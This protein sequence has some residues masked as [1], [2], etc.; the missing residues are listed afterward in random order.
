[1]NFLITLLRLLSVFFF[2]IGYFT[3]IIII[4]ILFIALAVDLDEWA[5]RL[6]KKYKRIEDTRT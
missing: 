3:F 1:M 2:F 5:D 4:G 6:E